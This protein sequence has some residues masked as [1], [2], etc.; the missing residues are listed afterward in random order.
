MTP[1]EL[2]TYC[3]QRYN[4][5]GD[6]F[7]GTTEVLN[8]I[9][10]ACAQMAREAQV[11][12]QVYTTS[13]AI[14]TS[15]YVY[16]TNA[17]SIKR[18]TYAGQKLQP[19]SFREDDQITGQNQA[20]TSSG[21]PQYYA[22]WNRTIYL[23]PVPD[24]VGTLKIFSFNTPQAITTASTLEIPTEYH[25]DVVLYVLSVFHSKEKNF[26]GADYWQKKWEQRLKEI[27]I[28]ERKKL[29]GDSFTHVNDIDS[30]SESFIGSV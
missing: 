11:I 25:L 13:T 14:G 20:A 9:F 1:T 15:E 10:D 3:R 12:R 23:R 27:K 8:I 21:T 17:V 5:V 4:A 22:E 18:I 2:D 6:T 29:R 16:P 28:N 7:W 30:M 26:Q 19:I 24:A